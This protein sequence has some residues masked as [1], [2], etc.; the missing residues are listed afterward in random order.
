MPRECGP[1]SWVLQNGN[2]FAVD[3]LLVAERA[4]PGWPAFAGHDSLVA[5]TTPRP[6]GHYVAREAAIRLELVT[7]ELHGLFGACVMEF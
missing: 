7:D 5:A 6:F 4:S 3:L 1:P 2:R